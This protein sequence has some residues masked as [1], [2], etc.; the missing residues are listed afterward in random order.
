MLR[1]V[2]E[3]NLDTKKII[4]EIYKN[5][6]KYIAHVIELERNKEIQTCQS[7]TE[8]VLFS[9]RS[10]LSQAIQVVVE[11]VLNDI[12]TKILDML[13]AFKHNQK[14]VMDIIQDE[15]N[16]DLVIP[17]QIDFKDIT[18]TTGTYEHYEAFKDIFVI[19]YDETLG[20]EIIVFKYQDMIKSIDFSQMVNNLS[21]DLRQCRKKYLSILDV[22]K[23]ND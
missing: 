8:A 14:F 1:R 3:S 16:K 18:I 13:P 4:S 11:N 5:N 15:I 17:Q 21:R 22:Q 20:H 6:A 9:Y 19:D 2:G 7:E 23:M 12:E 10:V